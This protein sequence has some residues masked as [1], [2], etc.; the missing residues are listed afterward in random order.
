MRSIWL[1]VLAAFFFAFTF[2]LNRSMELF[3]LFYASLCFAS[4]YS[5]VGL[6]R[7]PGK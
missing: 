4:A 3:V 6:S 7:G 1:G 5:R 2:V